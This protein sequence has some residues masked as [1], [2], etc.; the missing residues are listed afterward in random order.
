MSGPNANGH[1]STPP[2][3]IGP[4]TKVYRIGQRF[5]V[6]A[7]A[8]CDGVLITENVKVDFQWSPWFPGL[9]HLTQIERADYERATEDFAFV[10]AR[11]Y[12]V[13]VG[14]FKIEEA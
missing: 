12:D 7:K 1:A 10:I 13:D 4:L 14:K 3:P 2:S 9:E 8:R 6:K 5:V 11:Y